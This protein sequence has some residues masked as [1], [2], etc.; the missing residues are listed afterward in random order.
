MGRIQ[1]SKEL[2]TGLILPR[3]CEKKTI[4]EFTDIMDTFLDS[5]D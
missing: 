3:S 2:R 4:G 1:T 5:K